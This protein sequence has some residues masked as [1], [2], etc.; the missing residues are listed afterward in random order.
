[1]KENTTDHEPEQ[2]CSMKEHTLENGDNIKNPLVQEEVHNG[3][4]R[5]Q[6]TKPW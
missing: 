1:M 4:Q 2:W 6:T 5:R 3:V